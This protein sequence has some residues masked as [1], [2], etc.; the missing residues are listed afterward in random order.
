LLLLGAATSASAGENSPLSQASNGDGWA[1]FVADGDDF[2]IHDS[3]CDGGTVWAQVPY[4]KSG[5][6]WNFR[7][8]HNTSGC[9]TTDVKHPWSDIPEGAYVYVRACGSV[10]SGY[11]NSGAGVFST[12]HD[13]D[14]SVS[15]VARGTG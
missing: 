14:S 4:F 9:N 5:Y 6:G 3:Q 1:F 11:S 7:T 15:G 10:D 12:G 2:N 13:C 8:I